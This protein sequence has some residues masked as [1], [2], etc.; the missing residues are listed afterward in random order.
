MQAYQE[1]LPGETTTVILSP[2]SEFFRYFGQGAPGSA[3]KK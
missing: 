2:N 1:A 3:R